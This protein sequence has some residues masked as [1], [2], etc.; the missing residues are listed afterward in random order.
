MM[1]CLR[2]DM[3]HFGIIQ[4]A[5]VGQTCQGRTIVL[6]N[7]AIQGPITIISLNRRFPG[8]GKLGNRFSR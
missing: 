5:R 8:F 1:C 4:F 2:V 6:A 7:S 3:H